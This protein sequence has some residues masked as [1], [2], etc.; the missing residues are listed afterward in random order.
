M[1]QQQLMVIFAKKFR[2]PLHAKSNLFL[3]EAST[4]QAQFILGPNS[5]ILFHLISFCMTQAHVFNGRFKGVW[6]G[7]CK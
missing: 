7:G 1:I 5:F 6:F 4:S 3:G 2:K